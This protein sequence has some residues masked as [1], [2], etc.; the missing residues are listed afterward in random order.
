[1]R[2]ILRQEKIFESKELIKAIDDVKN[3]IDSS[4]NIIY[5]ITYKK[6]YFFALSIV[7]DEDIV[8]DVVQNV[9][10]LVHKNINSLKDNKMFISW[11]KRITYTE[12][13]K[14]LQKASKRPISMKDEDISAKLIEEDNPLTKY[15][16]NERSKEIMS[17]I[18]ELDEKY[19]TVIILQYFENYKLK[20]IGEILCCAEGT[21]KSRLHK[22]KILLKDKLSK[23]YGR[24]LTALLFGVLA[25]NTL[26]KTTY[27]ST[28][29][30]INKNE[31]LKNGS[32]KSYL[33]GG[34]AA[35]TIVTSS[36]IV[37][38]EVN[39]LKKPIVIESVQYEKGLSK[40]DIEVELVFSGRKDLQVI[41]PNNQVIS[42][43]YIDNNKAVFN[44]NENGAYK[45]V[46]SNDNGNNVEILKEIDIT[47]IDKEAP[48]ILN[49]EFNNGKL[50]IFL[51]DNLSGIDYKSTIDDLNKY[52]I[53][54]I[55]VDKS[56]NKLSIYLEEGAYNIKVIDLVGN[57]TIYD[58]NIEKE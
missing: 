55:E 36:V 26:V 1:M 48:V 40:D 17:D 58:I 41:S 21:V 9:Y 29:N 20:E 25:T 51:E 43:Y 3:G 39:E 7:K 53:N 4:F 50:D 18:L 32:L 14:E 45:V 8:N 33:V 2:C 57:Y 56:Q 42:L 31:L 34:I 30:L 19:R 16:S 24:V 10:I 27:A 6:V 49:A 52:N 13:I 15:L 5:K 37:I 12:S 22:G 47:N 11:I 54:N 28:I 46:Y 23:R 38:N 35:G 44:A